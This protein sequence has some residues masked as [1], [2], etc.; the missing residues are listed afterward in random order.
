MRFI[1]DSFAIHAIHLRFMRF[2]FAIHAIH[3]RFICDSFAWPGNFRS[4]SKMR[5][6]RFIL[7]FI[8]YSAFDLVLRSKNESQNESHESHE[9]QKWIAFWPFDLTKKWIAWIAKWI[10]F[11][12]TWSKN[13]SDIEKRSFYSKIG[14]CS[15]IWPSFSAVFSETKAEIQPT[16]NVY[17][18]FGAWRAAV[19]QLKTNLLWTDTASRG[20]I[21]PLETI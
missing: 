16:C 10:A 11:A 19:G 7:R 13:E 8:F 18:P 3:L 1:C 5:F 9:S 2:I 14:H 12:L 21:T 20:C 17:F 4:K 15:M 6:M